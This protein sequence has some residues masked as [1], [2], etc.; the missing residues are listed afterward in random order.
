[1]KKQRIYLDTSVFG[2][3]HDVEF[4]EFTEPLFK[5]IRNSEFEIILSDI[6]EDELEYV[7]EDIKSAIKLLPEDATV[8][9]KS[10]IES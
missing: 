4:Q 8:F 10:D 5:R 3:L 9:V 1:M 6:T 7:P 2:G